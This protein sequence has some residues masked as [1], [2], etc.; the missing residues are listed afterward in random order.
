M[1]AAGTRARSRVR[2]ARGGARLSP[3]AAI[4]AFTVCRTPIVEAAQRWAGELNAGEREAA[5]TLARLSR[6]FDATLLS[7]VHALEQHTNTVASRTPW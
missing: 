3:A 7:M 6:F 4:E 5:P 1:S 2:R